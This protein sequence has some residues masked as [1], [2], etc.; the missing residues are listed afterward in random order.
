VIRIPDPSLILLIG[1]SGAGKSTFAARHFAPTEI[2]SSDRCRAMICDDEAD[3]TVTHSAFA[4]LHHIT[5]ARLS[6]R[7]LTVI[8]ATN[9]EFRARRSLL[10]IARMYQTP[11]VAF[12]FRISLETCLRH[13]RA[14]TGRVVLED[15]LVKHAD[16]L[17]QTLPRLPREGYAGIHVLTETNLA[18][19]TIQRIAGDAE[20]NFF[21]NRR[22][23]Q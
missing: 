9:L 10:R 5:R 6:V 21:P 7:R 13:N 20:S 17:R 2:V 12:V 8:D 4:L 11:I 18:A 15:V 19:A 1:P 23:P 3:Q 14:R 22:I 16:E